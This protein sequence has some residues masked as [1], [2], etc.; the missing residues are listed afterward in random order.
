VPIIA[1]DV[2]EL[3]P[4]IDPTGMSAAAAAKVVRELLISLRV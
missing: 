1:L 3:A 4:G 2:V